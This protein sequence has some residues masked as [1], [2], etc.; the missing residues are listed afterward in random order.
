MR[1][2]RWG[3]IEGGKGSGEGGEVPLV[4]TCWVVVGLDWGI[5][6]VFGG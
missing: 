3:W 6:S 4:R 1:Y 2:V 5:S